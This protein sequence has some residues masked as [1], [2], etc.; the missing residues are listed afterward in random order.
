MARVQG[1]TPR[2][3]VQHF[4]K[5]YGT[6][7]VLEDVSLEVSAGETV[8]L[9][10]RSGSGKST[11]LASICPIVGLDAGDAY[12][13]GIRY[14]SRGLVSRSPWKIRRQIGL[15][16]QQLN[17]F[18]NYTALRNI[19]LP[20]ETVVGLAPDV[21]RHRA[22]ELSVLFGIED[23]LKQ[24][25]AELSGGQ[26]QR[27]ALARALALQPKVLLLDEITS[28]L[29]PETIIS[30]T[31]ALQTLRAT[32][33]FRDMCIVLATHLI[34]FAERFADRILFLHEG[35]IHEVGAAATFVEQCTLPETRQ[36][37]SAVLSL[38][39]P[40]ATGLDPN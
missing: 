15:V 13:D 30:V 19:T 38:R 22:R 40:A 20:L 27:V 37:V 11:L 35:R 33:E 10:G 3:L 28:A 1:M 12:L 39:L 4:K 24:F 31:A 17:L 2:L 7:K 36:F 21:A 34:P 32:D 14:V 8:A 18:D 5:S 29:D 16:F 26:A 25:P 6:R 9:I 23:H